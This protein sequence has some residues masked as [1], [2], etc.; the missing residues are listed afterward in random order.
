MLLQRPPRSTLFPYT[1]LFR[2]KKTFIG[3]TEKFP[4]R[5]DNQMVQ[6]FNVHIFSSFGNFLS[7]LFIGFTG[8]CV[9]AWV[10]VSKNYCSAQTFEQYGKK[11]S[12]IY[13]GSCNTS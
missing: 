12:H 6:Y 1:T 2:S 11:H 3:K 5:C 9:S 7:E 13:Q 4:V 10:I 8:V